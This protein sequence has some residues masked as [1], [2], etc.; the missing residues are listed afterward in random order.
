VRFDFAG[1]FENSRVQRFAVTAGNGVKGTLELIPGPSFN[2]LEV[3]FNTGGKPG[4][5]SQGNFLL[6]K[7]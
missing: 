5:I 6:T 1:A 4:T 2:L 3:N 7:Q